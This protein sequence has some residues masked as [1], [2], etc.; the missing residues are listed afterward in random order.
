MRRGGILLV[1]AAVVLLAGLPGPARAGAKLQISEDSSIDLG[2]R[3]QGL[4]LRTEKDLDRPADGDFE[5]VDDFKIRR[6]RLRVGADITRWVSMFIQTEFAEDPATG[7]GGGH[8][9]DRRFHQP[10]AAQAGQYLHR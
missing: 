3:L 9:G 10:Q 7:V 8:A 6:A 4:Y 2:F 1:A 5:T